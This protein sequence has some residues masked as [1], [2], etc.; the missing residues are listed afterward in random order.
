MCQDCKWG[1][2]LADINDMIESG[3]YDWAEDTLGGIADW[4]EENEHCTPG[5]RTAVENIRN[6]GQ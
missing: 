2:L 1:D 4:I 6:R 3:E 5:Q